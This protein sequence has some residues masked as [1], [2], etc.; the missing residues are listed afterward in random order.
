[1]EKL[2]QVSTAV[3]IAAVCILCFAGVMQA[4]QATASNIQT[5]IVSIH[6]GH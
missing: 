6:G 2:V 1:M 4:E 3:A 5:I